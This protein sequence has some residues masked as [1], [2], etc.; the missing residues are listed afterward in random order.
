M[1]LGIA[2][3]RDLLA[4]WDFVSFHVSALFSFGLAPSRGSCS[5]LRGLDASRL[6]P[7]SLTTRAETG[8]GDVQSN[9]AAAEILGLMLLGPTWAT[10]SFLKQSLRAEDWTLSYRST[11]RTEGRV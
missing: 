4:H 3:S 9:R 11:P 2:R 10:Q 7:S 8:L 6:P 5:A 1:A